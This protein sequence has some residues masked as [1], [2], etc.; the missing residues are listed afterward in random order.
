MVKSSEQINQ[1]LALIRSAREKNNTT[2]QV[3]ANENIKLAERTDKT[4]LKPERTQQKEPKDII[5]EFWTGI[6]EGA[7]EVYDNT[8]AQML[9]DEPKQESK[10]D[11]NTEK[12]K[13]NESSIEKQGKDSGIINELFQG[14]KEGASEVYDNT[15]AQ[16]LGDEPK[17]EDKEEN[18]NNKN[19]EEEENKSEST[20]KNKLRPPKVA[21]NTNKDKEDSETTDVFSQQQAIQSAI[22][23]ND[24]KWQAT[25]HDLSLIQAAR[26]STTSDNQANT[27]EE[28]EYAISFVHQ[29]N[30]GREA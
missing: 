24:T 19:N 16:I 23:S 7:S 4:I 11:S 29:H 25:Q 14:I 2:N 22:Q 17:Q 3:R 13:N 30:Q 12:D 8:V 28:K 1:E 20:H 27:T 6:T 26:N 15:V 10:E 9:G 21:K 18:R 5:D